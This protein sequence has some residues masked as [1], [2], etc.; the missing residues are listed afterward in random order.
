MHL[1]RTLFMV[2]L[3]LALISS[4]FALTPSTLEGGST[5]T[6][7]SSASNYQADDESYLRDVITPAKRTGALTPD[8]VNYL[9]RLNAKIA[10]QYI[11]N[12]GPDRDDEGGPDDFGYTWRD[13]E[14][15][16]VDFEWVDIVD[17]EGARQF[18]NL[19]DDWN[20]G[21]VELG[22]DFNF[23][24]EDYG[25]IYVCD[26]G[27]ISFTSQSGDYSPAGEFPNNEDPEALLAV[28]FTD[29]NGGNGGEIWYWS[30]ADEGVAIVS[31]IDYPHINGNDEYTF[32]VIINSD[33]E[34]Y[35]QNADDDEIPNGYNLSIGI[36]N[37]AR[38]DG[39]SAYFGNEGVGEGYA[40]AFKLQWIV[41]EDNPHIVVEPETLEFG[42]LFVDRESTMEVE[43]TNL[44][45]VDLTVTSITTEGDGFSTAVI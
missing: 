23:Y 40:V 17:A 32:Q 31:W 8:Q 15:N 42:Q 29:N 18:Q 37:G 20:S 34:I 16:L 4:G 22:W 41:D 33:G 9:R 1:F 3:T 2:V 7:N 44:G 13:D 36:Q 28:H 11:E 39:L 38:D 27:W 6:I 43:A 12:N 21:A 10:H 45:G 30:D 25:N 5:A 26:N 24:G 14:E 19:R 35:Y